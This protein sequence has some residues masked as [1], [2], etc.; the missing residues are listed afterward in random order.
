M[1][2]IE[3]YSGMPSEARKASPG[4]GGG[5]VWFQLAPICT[6]SAC[7]ERVGSHSYSFVSENNKNLNVDCRRSRARMLATRDAEASRFGFFSIRRCRTIWSIRLS[8]VDA[9][10]F[11]GFLSISS[12]SGNAQ[13]SPGKVELPIF[14]FKSIFFCN[15]FRFFFVDSERFPRYVSISSIR[16]LLP[17]ALQTFAGRFDGVQ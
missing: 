10:R 4:K 1:R 3:M 16:E 11:R 6:I 2:S 15:F 17:L 8:F 14:C 9:E 12:M 5:G 13:R 7:W